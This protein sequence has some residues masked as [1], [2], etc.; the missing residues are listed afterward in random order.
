M[1]FVGGSVGSEENLKAELDC[2]VKEVIAWLSR[3]PENF[4][5][6]KEWVK[7]TPGAGLDWEGK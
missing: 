4:N 6:G 5:L 7:E 1:V 2:Q 3:E